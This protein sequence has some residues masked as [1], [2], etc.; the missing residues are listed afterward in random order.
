MLPTCMNPEM[1]GHAERK[2]K[3]GQTLGKT[4]GIE[5][6]EQRTESNHIGPEE[7][8]DITV[9]E[10]CMNNKPTE[11]TCDAKP[12]T[13]VE[14]QKDNANTGRHLLG[15]SWLIQ[16]WAHL[17]DLYKFVVGRKVGGGEGS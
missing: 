7:G 4:D 13:N 6:G 14:I 15:G 17:P 11:E 12:S 5:D 8:G 2:K 3:T 10:R 9:K 16:V 1:E